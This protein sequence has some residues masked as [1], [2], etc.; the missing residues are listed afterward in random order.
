MRVLF[1]KE[2][3]ERLYR[4]GTSDKKHRFQPEIVK[5]YIK[6]VDV[7]IAVPNVQSLTFYKSLHYERLT[8][9]KIGLSSLRVNDK[10]RI[11]FDEIIEGDEQIASICN[12]VEQSNHYD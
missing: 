11:E 6:V 5:K 12:I 3:L 2:Y 9:D 8:G 1:D 4:T 10:Y 7:M